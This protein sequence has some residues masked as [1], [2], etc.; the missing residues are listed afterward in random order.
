MIEVIYSNTGCST[1]HLPDGRADFGKFRHAGARLDI[2]GRQPGGVETGLIAIEDFH[3]LLFL[4]IADHGL[5]QKAVQLGFGQ[6]IR[7]FVFDGI[8]GGKSGE[9]GAQ[10]VLLPS[11]ETCCSCIAS[12]KADWVFAGARLI[13]SA[14]SK[15]QKIGPGENWK[16]AECG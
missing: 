9:H 11:T 1:R 4:R 16:L 13:S 7:P 6:G 8:L 5:K 14:N 12:S 15:S 2:E 10:P 3:L